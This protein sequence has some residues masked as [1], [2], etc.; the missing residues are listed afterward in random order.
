MT[1]SF[2]PLAP[3]AP[4]STLPS[5]RHVA[6]AVSVSLALVLSACGGGG[7]VTVDAPATAVS[8]SSPRTLDPEFMARKAV[9]YSPFR[10]NN[11]DT[12]TITAA[13]VKEDMELLVK[14]NFRLIR[15]F[16][17][18]DAVSRLTLQVIHDN[19]F[20]IK[21]MLGAYVSS[22]KYA[23]AA[24]KP[25]IATKNQAELAR[26][27]ALANEFKSSV[28]AVSIG[29]ETMVSWSFN[30]IDPTVMGG[31]IASVRS[32]ITQPITTD[33][34][35]ALFATP[36]KAITDN[37]DFASMHTYAEL[38]SV[39]TASLWDWKQ[40]GVSTDLDAN[41]VPAR[42]AA[43]MKAAIDH[44]KKDYQSVRN[45]LDSKGLSAMPVVIGETGWN[46]VNLGSLSYRAHPVNQKLYYQALDD[47]GLQSRFGGG[48]SKIFYFEAFDEPWKGGDDKWGLFNVNR[49]ARYVVQNL[50]PASTTWVYEPGAYTL[51]D[52]VYYKP[53]VKGAAVTAARYTAY[54]DTTVAGS[55]NVFPNLAFN[56][57]GGGSGPTAAVPQVA[58]AAAPADGPNGIEITPNPDTF[59]WGVVLNLKDTTQADDLTNFAAG[60]LHFSIQTTYPGKIEV[61]FSTGASATTDAFDVWMP[62]ATGQY[63][64]ANDGAWH[65]V[66]IPVKDLIPFG[67]KGFGMNN[68]PD[69]VLDLSKVTIPFV[70]ADRYDHTGKDQKSGIRTKLNIDAIYWTR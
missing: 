38:D 24:D 17:S 11:R 2:T 62:L 56:A 34:N 8:I 28:L 31:Y 30:P 66:A 43:M 54:A 33:D 21:V 25:G 23:S 50:N 55:V 19:N 42:A 32:Q 65:D 5:W 4:R 40:A 59:G 3:W 22:D 9:A 37:I 60:T 18:S 15:L 10:S 53:L 48:P 1:T 27:V 64:Y 35:W 7:V 70:I 16:D 58:T 69:A 13:M 14:G 29:N 63:G 44:A 51:A 36:P 39:F 46:A 47:W 6:S 49:Q 68:S 26:T 52:A 57:F 67:A 12:E 41:G 45:A 20:D 61:G